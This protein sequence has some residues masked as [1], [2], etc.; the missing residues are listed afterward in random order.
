MEHKVK[1]VWS[2]FLAMICLCMVII[3]QR[4]GGFLVSRA[5][6]FRGKNIWTNGP[7]VVYGKSRNYMYKW[8]DGWQMTFC[9]APGNH[10]GSTIV[11]EAK[12][13]NIDD[14]DIPYIKSKE[15]YEKLAMICTWYDT[16]GSVHA[17]NATYGAA[18]AGIWAIMQDGWE[19]GDSIARIVSGHV[20]GTYE[21][22]EELKAYVEDAGDGGS[23]L[24]EWCS[25]SPVSGKTQQMVLQDGIWTASVDISSVPQ[26]AAL[27]WTFEGDSTGWS[28]SVA[29][30]KM[31]FS[32][33]GTSQEPMTLW[34]QLPDELKGFAKNTTSLN[35][36]I[37]KGDRSKIQAMISAGPFEAKIYLHLAFVPETTGG[38]IPEVHIY[39]HTETFDSQYNF[40]L[41]KYCAETGQTLEGSVFQVLE[42]FDQSQVD[43]KLTLEQMTPKPS[44]WSDFKICQEAGTDRD[45]SFSHTDERKY[46]YSKT[47]CDGHPEPE[48]MEVPEFLEDENGDN[49][50]EI[51]A[52]EEA[53][54]LLHAQWE[55]LVEACEEETDFHGMEPGEG[56]AMMLEDRDET[57][58]QFINLKYD[59]TVREIQARYGYIRHGLHP[60]DE[61][62]PV[63]RMTSSQAGADYELIEKEVRINKNAGFQ[64]ESHE[65]EEYKPEKTFLRIATGSNAKRIYRRIPKTLRTEE[66]QGDLMG[67]ISLPDPVDDDVPW[68]EPAGMSDKIGYTFHVY[69]HRTEG[70]LHINKRDL[71]LWKEESAKYDSYG[72]TQGDG[73]LEGAVYGLYA[74]EDVIH[75]DGKT[76]TV[77]KK[78][79]LTSVAAT[80]QKGD[81]SFLAYTEESETL[82]T[83][84]GHPLI[85]GQY[86]VK[87]IARSEGYE[88]SVYGMDR[89]ISNQHTDKAELKTAGRA[90]V[91][92]AL[93]HPIDM[94][95]GSWLEFDVTYQDT[96][97]GFDLLI[98]GYPEGAVFYRSQMKETT[99]AEQVVIGSR[100]VAT[101]EYEKA[102]EGEYRLDEE[103]NYMPLFDAQGNIVWDTDNPV[104]RVY[105][106]AR[107]LNYYPDRQAVPQIDPGK[108][109]DSEH[110]DTDYIKEETNAMLKQIGYG[111]L[112][113]ETGQDAP[114]DI[115][116]LNGTTNQELVEELLEWFNSQSFWDSG[117]IH[118]VWEED[119]AYKAAVFYDYRRLTNPC[120][121]ESASNK[122]YVRIPIHVAGGQERHTYI[123]W[124]KS[125]LTMEGGYICV[126]VIKQISE[127]IPFLAEIEE[128]L[129]PAYWPLYQKYKEGDYRLD[130]NGEKIP[131][132]RTEFIYGEKQ[133]TTSDYQLTPLEA[134][135]DSLTKS[136][137]IHVDNTV[138]WNVTDHPV[139]ET[140]RAACG[141][142]DILFQGD[143]MFYSDYLSDYT[144]AGASA[145]VKTE[146]KEGS[147]IRPVRL[148]YPGQISPMQDGEGMPG[149]GTRTYPVILQERIIKQTIKVT[150][151]IASE[152]LSKMD[153]FRFK[154]YLKSNL[155]GLYR[156]RE[157]QIVWTDPWGKAI[158]VETLKKET[159]AIVPRLY[160][161]DSQI[162]VLETREIQM[163]D[164]EKLRTIEE[165]NYEK[166]F[167]ALETA[168]HDKWDDRA[169]SYTSYRPVGNEKNR[170]GH[171]I[172]NTKISDCVRQFAIDWYLDEE[173]QAISQSQ[174]DRSMAYGDQ[175]YDQALFQAIEK[176]EDYLK[177]FFN[178]DLDEIY[179]IL[180]D[181]EENGGKDRDKAT[182]SAD[183]EEESHYCGTSL[184]LP[185]GTYVIA[186][187]QP[188]YAEL[189]D[190][191]N[192][193]YQIDR[194]K[195]LALPS[196]YT[197]YEASLSYPEGMSGYY[198]Y[199][200][201]M[202]PEEM[203]QKYLI[204]FNE[205]QRCVKA[206]NRSGDFV[207]YP[208]GLD[209]D[210][211]REEGIRYSISEDS[212]TADGVR[213]FGGTATKDNPSGRYYKDRVPAMAGIRTAYDGL[214]S[215]VLVPWSV[216][217]PEDEKTDG[218]PQL[219]GESS[220]RGYAYAKFRNLCYG[221][222][223]RIEK[224]DS[225][226]HEN[227]LHDG[228]IFRIYTAKRD[229]SLKGTGKVK[230]YEKDTVI[231][232]SREFLEAMG[233]SRI[234]PMARGRMLTDILSM[235]KGEKDE[236]GPGNR[237]T[238]LI[239]AG[240][241]VCEE[242]D[243]VCMDNTDGTKIGEFQA[244]TTAGEHKTE[245]VYREQNT[246]YLETPRPLDAGTYVLAEVKAP[247]G[248]A[249][250]RPVAI[251]LYSDKIAYY[252]EGNQEEQVI[253]TVYGKL[254]EHPSKNQNKPE[255][256]DDLARIYV[257]NGPVKLKVE[258]VKEA[259]ETV[260]WQISGRID[261]SLAQI[262]NRDDCEYAYLNG[263]YQGYGWKK[264]TLEYLQD[265]KNKG[266]DIAII[267][268]GGLFAGYGYITRKSQISDEDNPYV[269]GARMTMFEGM[270]LEPSGDG[271]DHT[272]Q[273]LVIT[274]GIDQTVTGMYVQKGY[275]GT[276]TEFLP[277]AGEEGLI[278]TSREAEREN[279]DILYYDLGGLDVFKSQSENGRNILYGYNRNH[280]IIP[281]HLPGGELSSI[282]AFKGARPCLEITGGDFDRISYS[283]ADKQFTG[284]FAGLKRDTNGN[285]TFG[286]GMILYHLDENGD[287]DSLVD[288]KTG[289]AY[290]LEEAEG[291]GGGRKQRILVWPVKTARDQ[292]GAVIARDK[293]TT[294]RTA[295]AE[296][297]QTEKL[298]KEYPES[299]YITGS[300]KTGK[301]ERSHTSSTV[302]QNQK[303]QNLNGEV[304]LN[305]N[306][307]SFEK[308]LEPV[309]NRHG[310][311]EY[312]RKGSGTYHESTPLYDRNGDWV[313]EKDQ[314][315][316]EAYRQAAYAIEEKGIIAHRCGEGYILENTWI[317]GEKTPNDPFRNQMT[318]G[319]ADIIKRVPAGVYILEEV[320]APE[321]Y[322][323]G[324]PAGITVRETSRLQTVRMT[325]YST[326]L[327][328]GKIDG[329]SKYTYRILDMQKK[330]A[331]GQWKVLGTREEGKGAYGLSQLPGAQLALYKS[332]GTKKADEEPIVRWVT[333]DKP[334]YLE[335][336]PAGEYILEES[337][338][339][340]GF[341][342]GQPVKI[343]VENTGEVQ[344][345]LIYNDHTKI[346]IEKYTLDG[347]HKKLAA[348]AEFSLYEA[349]T[350]GEGKVIMK[351]GVPQYKE[352]A[353]VDSWT[354][355]DGSEYDDFIVEFEEMYRAYGTEGKSISWDAGGK[356]KSAQQ[357]SCWQIDSS[358]SGGGKSH[359][360]TTAR[361]LYRTEDGA[362][363]RITVYESSV[364]EYQ[365][366]CHLL[367]GQSSDGISYLTAEGMRRLDYLPAGKDYIL[368]E[369][370]APSGCAKAENQVIHI[371]DTADIQRYGVLNQ[372]GMLLIS[373]TGGDT[374][375]ELPG[376]QMA[377]YRAA[378]DG[379]FVQDDAHMAARWISGSDGVYTELE[380]INRQ[381][382]EGYGQGDLRPHALRRLPDGI[383][384]LTELK[385][386]DYYTV[387]EPVKIEYRQQEKIQ[388]IRVSDTVAEGELEISKT[389]SHG[390]PLS[391]AVFRLSAYRETDLNKPVFT[392]TYGEEGGRLKITGLPVGQVLD[393]G[394]VVPY[395]Y[396]L[397]EVI[398]PSGYRADSSEHTFRF[399]EA[400]GNGSYKTGETA[401]KYLNI[402][403]EKTRIV[404]S[405]KDFY[406]PEFI[407]GAELAVYPVT[408]RDPQQNYIYDES[409]PVEI[410]RTSRDGPLK[411]LEG[412]TAGQ[413]YVL[414]ERQAPEGYEYMKPVFFTISMDGRRVVWIN[415][416]ITAI[417]AET[418]A[419]QDSIN[420]LL[421][422]GRYGVKTEMTAADSG[423]RIL[424]S[425]VAG[426]DGYLLPKP[427]GTEDGEVC[428]ITETTVFSDGTR[429][430]TRRMTK[431]LFWEDG[432]CRIPDRRA[433]QVTWELTHEDGT[434]IQSFVPTE[435]RPQWRIDNPAAR[436]N[437]EIRICNRDGH[438]GDGLN[439]GQ[440]VFNRITYT[441]TSGY[442]ADLEL[443]VTTGSGTRVID[444]GA[445]RTDGNGWTYHMDGADPMESGTIVIVTEIDSECMES[446]VTAELKMY[447]IKGEKKAEEAE[448]T[449]KSVKT[450]PVLQKSMLTVFH[451]LTGTGQELC[452]E[453]ESVF[454]IFLYAENGEELKGIYPYEGSKTGSLT[455]GDKISLKGNQYI[456]VDPGRFHPCIE[457][458]VVRQEDGEEFISRNIQGK[459][460]KEKGAC[461]VFTRSVTDTGERN[462][463]VKGRSYGLREVTQYSDGMKIPT[464]Q[465]QFT[466]NE[467][468]GINAITGFD[469][470]FQI[471][472]RK[473]DTAGKAIPGAFLQILDREGQILEQWISG[474]EAH[475]I[476]AVL[477]DGAA[478]TL[479]EESAPNGYGYCEDICFTIA[480][481]GVTEQIVMT[482]R[483]TKVRIRKTDITGENEIPG[484]EMQILDSDRNVVESWTSGETPHE[485]TGKLTAGKEYILHEA[486]APEGYAYGADIR[487]LIPKDGQ[488]I[489]VSMKDLP[490]HVVIHK[491]DITGEKEIPGAILRITG[492][493]GIVKE[494]WESGEKPYNI[495]GK[496]EAGKEYILHESYAPK[497]YAYARDI[498]FTVSR[499]GTV[500]QVKMK[501]DIT[502]V[503]VRKT[504]ITG[505]KEV[506]GAALKI[507]DEDGKI[508]EAWISGTESHDVRGKLEAGK[509]YTLRE[510]YAPAGYGYSADVIFSVSKDGTVDQVEMKDDVT[511][512]EVV[513]IDR[514]SGR[515][516][517]G[518]R[519][520][521]LTEDGRI[522]EEW[523]SM[524]TPHEIYGKLTAGARYFIQEITPPD[525]YKKMTEKVVCF[526]PKD[527]SLIRSVIE[528]RKKPGGGTETPP[529]NPEQPEKPQEPERPKELRIGRVLASYRSR[530]SGSGRDSFGGF[531][532]IRN[533]KTGDE[534]NTSFTLVCI[535]SVLSII[536][537]LGLKKRDK[538]NSRKQ[539]GLFLCIIFA[540]LPFEAKAEEVVRNS[541][542][543]ITV[544]WEAFTE[545]METP[546]KP[547]D[548]YNY[549]GQDYD[550]KSCQ[551]IS[552][553]TEEKEKEV[554]DTV[555]YKAV[556]QADTLPA[557]A[558]IQIVDEDT[559]QVVDAVMPALDTRF[560]NWRWTGGFQFPITVQ[561]YD[562]GI[563]YLG[564]LTVA[565]DEEQPFLEYKKE[566]LDLIDVN[567]DF[568]SIEATRW[569]SQPWTGEDGLVYRQAM[570]S[571]RKYVA[572]CSVTYGGTA[573]I[574]AVHANAWQAVY[575]KDGEEEKEQAASLEERIPGQEE[576]TKPE[577]SWK[578]IIKK[579]FCVT[580]GILFLLFCLMIFYLILVRKNR[581]CKKCTNN[582][583]EN[584]NNTQKWI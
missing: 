14:E 259:S 467:E 146:D 27:N 10:M 354:S 541:N 384:Y 296:E 315:L 113:P 317:T 58:H 64:T 557:E 512:L 348:G 53:N 17:D 46:E 222:K 539:W 24:P 184:Y 96:A 391:G 330:D 429:Q 371:E 365:F 35:L 292:Y 67:D 518:A 324:F 529:E 562:A 4:C 559:G 356:N 486:N 346:E 245:S 548:T 568:Y 263:E 253:A 571:G 480:E 406:L 455:S 104:S 525:G 176:A 240:T 147:Y 174:E 314:D 534:R 185:Y 138:D 50:G 103:G 522:V 231:S 506:A 56:L 533:P 158:D 538:K 477:E 132:Y 385:A 382:P 225:E 95:D 303:G 141:Q 230:F 377:L 26:L 566:L 79:Q 255:D 207:I 536:G 448:I 205:E 370:R 421:I 334:F 109:S 515:P 116:D 378:D 542:T 87:E 270:E 273:G 80:D 180:W 28:K 118:R 237:Y 466:L 340:D 481:E 464:G 33:G 8:T 438:P 12:R 101:G 209:T 312:Y 234:T 423:G 186:E 456:T 277:E 471:S 31:T 547:A 499:D 47:Y 458:K 298:S 256:W 199:D 452:R 74:A 503:S 115:L 243:Q 194:P 286:D 530:L 544:T 498:R 152:E 343:T 306:P 84:A 70:E 232:G 397:K 355:S 414:A 250:T 177:P 428:T 77:Y 119:G 363:I 190:L 172:E 564:D 200:A 318:E 97:E 376:A 417:T 520:Q 490:T 269:A 86:Y 353:P 409:S 410:W 65:D 93:T 553:M 359:F 501:D 320:Q 164:G 168:N 496:L 6:T 264:G 337:N 392:K 504:D 75:P 439:P 54:E 187:Q 521:L 405:K 358:V 502:W 389:D 329:T 144:G 18:Q 34:A 447:P 229:D 153:N 425:W 179:A 16:H 322:T 117:A 37:P 569:T 399:R 30:G 48:Y 38:E 282:F 508:V 309:L 305:D 49:S 105:Y 236:R 280:E 203:T 23:G 268:H 419:G 151:D 156:S 69:N 422:Q 122:I 437:P 59:Y 254:T 11:A 479:H 266:E 555:V 563:F 19:S 13:T 357:I 159:P 198:V 293:I 579:I 98:S 454:E 3:P 248:Y 124:R 361:L 89:E 434:L 183:L 212:R 485:I 123:S 125:Q 235:R 470:P 55:A 352:A 487:F 221:A 462:V 265:L 461:A 574:P 459:T 252:K 580:V 285:Y 131:V 182:V 523:D 472:V 197:D 170:T 573:A 545:N 108:W 157:G 394:K 436:E 465:I 189:E 249:R 483:P 390:R 524:E 44:S 453:E 289:M 398:P 561:Q 402:V 201:K 333:E 551:I 210:R 261:G 445:G 388:V 191:P 299:G 91:V 110:T 540:F 369:T 39:R 446:Q 83:A 531:K 400:A 494:Q 395:T 500:D 154:A 241:P 326:K 336:I 451:E 497:G 127:E 489:Q 233:A 513:K 408:G 21:K 135:Y 509:T 418:A 325:D 120:I 223:L 173:I 88:L 257:E 297:N 66:D 129:E 411:V 155:T 99:G 484:A 444:A 581:R 552:V 40:D 383:Y 435:D 323:K 457:Y 482:D 215:S 432:V 360:P 584:V 142:T 424:A 29:D 9:I 287:R 532:K 433:E 214:Y 519:L 72:D 60:D 1:R 505:E 443:V 114:W 526:I 379:G 381:I 331:S 244:Y 560:E 335:R 396:R 404:I 372:E 137:K 347:G 5:A 416:R 73:T 42:A 426:G 278:W 216:I 420:S 350:D 7:E 367:A 238:G 450:V 463:I 227:I 82:K 307:G 192:R 368:V 301:G 572:D 15:D 247:A 583:N 171:A 373:K 145:F 543:E 81:A 121:Y 491:T 288:P 488:M 251:E 140:F 313:R 302:K 51:E 554:K 166:F 218:Q 224:L 206:H 387:M 393:D 272:Y 332:D 294:F 575:T 556:E 493:D 112:D 366:D 441:N 338:V 85:L 217:I 161:Q 126:P 63:V 440:E 401:K 304:L 567:P 193:H 211:K 106:A 22:W 431:P 181:K 220:Y 134:S 527:G 149:E 2:L 208:Y 94:H 415:N 345:C 407:E 62:I 570:A 274:R 36:Y 271:G 550:L 546:G 111:L 469:R 492:L 195:E 442:K 339:P 349:L 374:K 514:S 150:K 167:D 162:P 281:I 342:T 549:N 163:E 78:G 364:F 169:P 128:Y 32:Y 275:A 43:G 351:D 57:Y 133:E 204:R 68:I 25:A 507:L 279:T 20:A 341:V 300:W 213:F 362:D 262:G 61:K 558:P 576:K 316:A 90:D 468:G 582:K 516:L 386:P 188:R 258:K 290:V 291:A 130:G 403:N 295:T 510:E 242:K 412:L 375:Q 517:T 511:K 311:V 321:G 413:T 495:V 45:G 219:S 226:T 577:G 310:L 260:T 160:T 284:G 427:A 41:K 139:T 537:M 92:T 52:V 327:L 328:V 528:N 107:R 76:G 535:L 474:K 175:W 178:Y 319:Q 460:E 473:E 202:T 148:T 478:Y 476:C 344:N 100:L 308:T 475:I 565:G 165:Y 267:Y 102:A 228:A 283:P 246:G 71:D 239:P 449:K 136:Y 380:A 196:V 276:R 430:T 143:T 578:E